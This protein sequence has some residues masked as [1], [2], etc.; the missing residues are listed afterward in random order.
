ME[1]KNWLVKQQQN[2]WTKYNRMSPE[3][4]KWIYILK[5][6]NMNWGILT[7]SRTKK[8]DEKY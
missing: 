7:E 6:K 2:R 4:D 3:A 1:N 5:K 8:R